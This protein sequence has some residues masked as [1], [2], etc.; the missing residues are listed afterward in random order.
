MPRVPICSNSKHIWKHKTAHDVCDICGTKF[1]CSNE[2][3]GHEDCIEARE[4]G[5]EAWNRK[6]T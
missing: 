3:C 2:R 4:I 6:Y 5:V 1:P